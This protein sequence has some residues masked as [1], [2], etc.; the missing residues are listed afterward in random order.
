VGALADHAPVIQR[1]I[2]RAVIF[3][4][5]PVTKTSVTNAMRLAIPLIQRVL[6]TRLAIMM[7]VTSVT[8]RATPSMS[9]LYAITHVTQM[10]ATSATLLVT[11]RPVTCVTTHAIVTLATSVMP[12]AMRATTRRMPVPCVTNR[13]TMTYVI[14]AMP[15]VTLDTQPA[16]VTLPAMEMSALSVMRPV[17]GTHAQ[18]AT[19]HVTRT[20]VI[21]ATPPVM[22]GVTQTPVIVILDAL[23]DLVAATRPVTLKP[24]TFV[25]LRAIQMLVTNVTRPVTLLTRPVHATLLVTWTDATPVI[26]LVMA[27]WPVP[28]AITHATLMLVTSATPHRMYART[29]AV[30]NVT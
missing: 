6:V 16:L 24:V 20:S 17:M 4:I 13:A 14:P 29:Q 1:A 7:S 8:L 21:S 30:I 11:Q 23:G 28:S 19:I 27:M 5:V 2:I 15:L 25:T 18:L 22:R 10:P 3:A 9:V 12:V 26:H